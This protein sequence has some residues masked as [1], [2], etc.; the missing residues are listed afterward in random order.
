MK[1]TFLLGFLGL[2]LAAFQSASAVSPFEAVVEE[3]EV[4]I[5][6]FVFYDY[7]KKTFFLILGLEAEV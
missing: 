3:W 4:C 1:A 5:Q 6:S 2:G 7:C